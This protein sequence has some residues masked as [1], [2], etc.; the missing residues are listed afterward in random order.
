MLNAWR[1]VIV[2]FLAG[3]RNVDQVG[4]EF[5][6]RTYRR[7]RYGRGCAHAVTSEAGFEFQIGGKRVSDEV[8]HRDGRLPVERRGLWAIVVVGNSVTRRIACHQPAVVTPVEAHPGAA[9]PRLILQV[10]GLVVLFVVVDAKYSA[11]RQRSRSCSCGL[12]AE[13][14]GGHTG[15]DYEGRESLVVWDAD[16]A[17]IAWNLGFRPLDRKCDGRI[18]QD[19]EIVAQV[20]VLP[21]VLPREN[22]ILSES[23]FDSDVVFIP[24]AR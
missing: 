13:E 23:L 8:G 7:Q 15:K 9:F 1:M 22:E 16:A 20:G 17:R 6:R 19:A 4:G 14:P 24:Q 5:V 18:T 2:I 10:R 12:L 11:R 3:R 21:N